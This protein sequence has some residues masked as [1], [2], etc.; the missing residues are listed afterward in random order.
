MKS[1]CFPDG[2]RLL[3]LHCHL[4]SDISDG[5]KIVSELRRCE[6]SRMGII[7]LMIFITILLMTMELKYI[8][9]HCWHLLLKEDLMLS[10]LEYQLLNE[11]KKMNTSR[12]IQFQKCIISFGP[13]ATLH[14]II[15]GEVQLSD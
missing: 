7:L 4:H 14:V 5:K 3:H 2:V 8:F 13:S 1:C 12:A 11:W 10:T 6:L 15:L 9:L